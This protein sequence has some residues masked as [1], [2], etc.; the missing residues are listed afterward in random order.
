MEPLS[1]GNTF[2]KFPDVEALMGLLFKT[3]PEA[4]ASKNTWQNENIEDFS[5]MAYET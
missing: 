1:Y 4:L 3:R 5:Q 2:F